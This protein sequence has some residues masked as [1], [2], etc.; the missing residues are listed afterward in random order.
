M[1]KPLLPEDEIDFVTELAERVGRLE[2]SLTIQKIG[3]LTNAAGGTS[4]AASGQLGIN[5]I[6][7]TFSHLRLVVRGQSQYGAEIDN[8]GIRFNGDSSANYGWMYKGNTQAG[9]ASGG[10]TA[11]T[12]GFIGWTMGTTRQNDSYVSHHIIDIPFYSLADGVK[13][14]HSN[15]VYFNN[16]GSSLPWAGGTSQGI[17]YLANPLTALSVFAIS[18]VLGPRAR[19]TLY[20]VL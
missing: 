5:N 15:S 8:M 1:T 18:A 12:Y 11:Q 13:S 20:G 19:A 16:T 10:T 7:P 9:D 17:R 4:G 3:E 2:R 6:P 14:W